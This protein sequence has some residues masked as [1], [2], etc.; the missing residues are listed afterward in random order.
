M[1]MTRTLAPSLNQDV[2][3]V[4][5]ADLTQLP[6]PAL[7]L[8]GPAI[9]RNI[10]RLANY[11]SEVGI[12]IRP[13]TKTHKSRYLAALQLD[14]GACGITCAKVSEVERISDAGQDVLLAYPPVGAHRAERLA[15]LARDRTVRAAV[16]SLTAVTAAS[17]AARAA[18]V[19]LSLLVDLDVG[20][21]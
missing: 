3:K 7:V 8:D 21:G 19:T 9:R 13:H 11:S 4:D 1:G 17:D 15:A 5:L 14:A 6:T 16:D 20:M 2:A 10:E 18:N 12:K